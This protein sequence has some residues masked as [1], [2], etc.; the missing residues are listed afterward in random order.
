VSPNK[1]I[2]TKE[3]DVMDKRM[4]VKRT[5]TLLSPPK[6]SVPHLWRDDGERFS[7]NHDG[8][9]TM[10]KNREAQPTCFYRYTYG[11]LMD[12]GVFSVY[13][14]KTVGTAEANRARRTGGVLEEKRWK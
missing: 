2:S 6:N 9:Y 4:G 3:E 10:D 11:R 8:T 13:P 1:V 7:R 12:T 5:G 14:P